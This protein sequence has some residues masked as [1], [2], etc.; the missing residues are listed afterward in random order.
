MNLYWE[1]TSTA[2]HEGRRGVNTLYS[3]DISQR[4]DKK[5]ENSEQGEDYDSHMY[6]LHC[7]ARTTDEAA[8]WSRIDC[9]ME[10]PKSAPN[11]EFSIPTILH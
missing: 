10:R 11:P 7:Y 1:D 9:L 3:A 8:L 6:Q 4:G 2:I 5:Q